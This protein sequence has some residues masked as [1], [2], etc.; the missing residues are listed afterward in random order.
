MYL[1]FTPVMAD[2]WR[3]ST[4]RAARLAARDTAVESILGAS[5][6]FVKRRDVMDRVSSDGSDRGA[7]A[8]EEHQE[9]HFM[10]CNFCLCTLW[11][12]HIK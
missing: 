7:A 4:G 1:P 2:M 12:K 9:V 10:Y 3:A 8:P 5:R 6:R 11:T